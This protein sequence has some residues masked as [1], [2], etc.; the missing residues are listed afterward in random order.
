MKVD[1]KSLRL[2]LSVVSKGTLAAA[3]ESEH[4]A[5]AALSKRISDLEE[6]LGA[7][8]LLRNNKGIKPTPAGLALLDFSRRLLHEL[9]S[10]PAHMAD[11]TRGLKGHVRI[12]ANISSI[13][14]FLPK[15][16]STFLEKNPLVQV[17]LEE[18]VSTE[19]GRGV[20]EN[21]ADLGVLVTAT[22]VP[23]IKYY[24]Y[25]Q[26]HLMLAV[27]ADHPLA[28]R[29][30]VKYSQTLA[31]E[32]IGL[33]TGSQLNLQMM[34]AASDLGRTWIC[35]MQVTSYDALCLMIEAGLGIG[36][37]PGAIAISYAK[38]LG[39]VPVALNETWASRVFSICCRP[40]DE[41]SP[42]TRLL[43]NHLL[44]GRSPRP[45]VVDPRSRRTFGAITPDS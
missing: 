10:L 19:V 6:S 8:L 38:A 4:I 26:D 1:P 12:F 3:A 41:L 20:A 37:L 21:A 32:F 31:Y 33:H 22:P 40:Y 11:F 45:D 14:Q 35:R 2:F 17:H 5:A 39:I 30:S 9:D 34:R 27:P 7:E 18:R 36:V 25:A 24:N 42:A 16:L 29:K 23:G 15:Q 13:T 28:S 43:L 44:A